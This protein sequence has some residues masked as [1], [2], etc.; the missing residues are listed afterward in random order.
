MTYALTTTNSQAA[1]EQI[2]ELERYLHLLYGRDDP[3]ALVEVRFRRPRGPMRQR[4]YV[5]RR[6]SELG[7][8]LEWL[9]EAH[10]VYVGVC[11]RRRRGGRALRRRARVGAMGRL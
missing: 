7:R 11:P 10:D 3:G 2:A 9:S 6:R 8:T 1:G 5:A 4:F